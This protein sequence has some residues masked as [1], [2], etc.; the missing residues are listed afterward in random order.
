MADKRENLIPSNERTPDERRRIAVEGGKASGKSRRKRKVMRE[1]L[2]TLM[3]LPVPEESA[4]ALIRQFGAEEDAN[5]QTA[6]LV[7]VCQLAMAGDLD[8]TKFLRDTIGE[9]PDDALNLKGEG[10]KFTFERAPDS[11]TL[12]DLMG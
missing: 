4:N 8:A 1:E 3:S 5:I 9:K 11:V 12:D 2:E 7:K 10:V 6:I